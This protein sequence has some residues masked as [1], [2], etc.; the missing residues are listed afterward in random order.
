MKYALAL[1]ALIVV[2]ALVVVDRSGV[3]ESQNPVRVVGIYS[4]LSYSEQSGT[5]VGSSSPGDG[6]RIRSWVMDGQPGRG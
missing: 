1:G 3:P 6:P 5:C 4:D 2:G